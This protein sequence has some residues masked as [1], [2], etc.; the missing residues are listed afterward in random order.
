[1]LKIIF[2]CMIWAEFCLWHKPKQLCH[3]AAG[4]SSNAFQENRAF[5]ENASSCSYSVSDLMPIV[6][7]WT[8]RC[9]RYVC[10]IRY[11]QRI[12]CRGTCDLGVMSVWFPSWQPQPEGWVGE[13]GIKTRKRIQGWHVCWGGWMLL[14]FA[15]REHLHWYF[16]S[17]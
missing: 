11:T 12:Y 16:M 17:S 7:L 14:Q 6:T 1:M 9:S 3:L 2:S 15:T 5:Q 10:F 13:W 4:A 8:G